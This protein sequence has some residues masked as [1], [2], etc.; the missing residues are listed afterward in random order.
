MEFATLQHPLKES[1]SVKNLLNEWTTVAPQCPSPDPLLMDIAP[2]ASEISQIDRP[3]ADRSSPA[4]RSSPRKMSTVIDLEMPLA[5]KRNF[6][7]EAV[8]TAECIPKLK[9]IKIKYKAPPVPIEPKEKLGNLVHD[10]SQSDIDVADLDKMEILFGLINKVGAL[11]YPAILDSMDE[12][13]QAVLSRFTEIM[14]NTS[15]Y[16]E[17][18]TLFQKSKEKGLELYSE[19]AMQSLEL[20]RTGLLA[21]EIL[22]TLMDIE[23]Q[24]V[25][26]APNKQHLLLKEENILHIVNGLKLQLTLTIFASNTKSGETSQDN[27]F[28]DFLQQVSLIAISTNALL[29]KTRLLIS[30]N[31]FSDEFVISV[32]YFC[33]ELIF[34][35]PTKEMYINTTNLAIEATSILSVVF[36]KYPMH[37]S[38]M[39][40]EIVCLLPKLGSKSDILR[41][42]PGITIHLFSSLIFQLLQSCAFEMD[43]YTDLHERSS[44]LLDPNP[45]KEQ[46]EAVLLMLTKSKAIVDSSTKWYQFFLNLLINRCSG[47]H[48]SKM[49]KK[50]SSIDAEYRSILDWFLN[51]LVAL[52]D[53]IEF[54]VCSVLSVHTVRY[55]LQI[56]EEKNETFIRNTITEWLGKVSAKFRATKVASKSE[57]EESRQNGLLQLPNSPDVKKDLLLVLQGYLNSTLMF[58]EKNTTDVIFREGSFKYM[59]QYLQALLIIPAQKQ[60][61]I[62]KFVG[63]G[64]G[65]FQA[66]K[67]CRANPTELPQAHCFHILQFLQPIDSLHDAIVLFLAKGIDSEIMTTRGKS[68]K[69]LAELLQNSSVSEHI[70][71]VLLT[72]VVNRLSDSSATVRDAA[73]DVLTKHMLTT[74]FDES[75][76]VFTRLCERILDVSTNVR[77]RIVKFMREL[78]Y[79]NIDMK[80]VKIC[81][82]IS[83]KIMSRLHDSEETV[84]ELANKTLKEIWLSQDGT[85]RLEQKARVLAE[86]LKTDTSSAHAFEDFLKSNVQEVATCALDPLVAKIV[87]H[88]LLQH[89]QGSLEDMERSLIVLGVFSNVFGAFCSVHIPLLYPFVTLARSNRD[90]DQKI[91]KSVIGIIANSV[92]HW[93]DPDL[94][95]LAMIEQELLG[96][97]GKGTALMKAAVPCLSKIAPMT[98]GIDKLAKIVTKCYTT[99]LRST[100]QS[101]NPTIYRCLLILSLVMANFDFE[102]AKKNKRYPSDELDQILNGKYLGDAVFELFIHYAVHL[103]TSEAGHVGLEALW[104]FC[105]R[106]SKFL[107]RKETMDLIESILTDSS[108]QFKYDFLSMLGDFIEKN[109]VKEEAKNIPITTDV[110]IGHSDLLSSEGIPS[111]ITQ[112]FLPQ[113]TE[114]LLTSDIKLT[115]LA[116]RVVAFALEFGFVHPITCIPSLIILES[117]SDSF[118]SKQALIIHKKLTQKHA[119]FI[120]SKNIESILQLFKYRQSLSQQPIGHNLLNPLYSLLQPIKSKRNDF[121]KSVIKLVQENASNPPLVKFVVE[122]IGTLEFQ[123]QEEILHVIHFLNIGITLSDIDDDLTIEDLEDPKLLRQCTYV[124]YLLQLREYLQRKY[125]VQSMKVQPA[126]NHQTHQE[127][128]ITGKS[129]P[130]EVV[131]IAEPKEIVEKVF[132]FSY[133]V[134]VMD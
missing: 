131:G 90:S 30:G 120:H 92:D 123:T 53:R 11:W 68:I 64:Q 104:M 40:E 81:C 89:K 116:F 22:L 25:K 84:F 78:W 101:G 56:S 15:R 32:I 117:H 24:A 3:I 51:D 106:N 102:T 100:K 57:L 98:N 28:N 19:G 8:S 59:I 118:L 31:V 23:A 87:D 16:M 124:L 73:V 69:S 113:I 1:F 7:S 55:F 18:Y 54:P 76:G 58:I 34:T 37:R 79:Q 114:L 74:T 126:S 33:N 97:L 41:V 72:S 5:E 65:T 21:A 29:R 10:L 38:M 17:T 85:N 13:D 80:N 110:L 108:S 62:E 86:M 134:E 48:S 44:I 94:K 125:P 88:I 39:L 27:D 47:D 83:L 45:T 36:G 49:N 112:T 128:L 9:K 20:I 60:G 109:Q 70:K 132:H 95:L 14:L 75:D 71:K 130:L 26:N 121:L 6:E 122:L 129:L 105:F 61:Q 43:W 63:F 35:P 12:N 50:S 67:V 77:K 46:Y 42:A 91:A 103:R 52:F 133:V 4:K 99:L 115:R 2:N 111:S 119:S 82:I 93:N 107:I 66:M 96:L 127:K